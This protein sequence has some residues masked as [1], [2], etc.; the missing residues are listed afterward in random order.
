MVAMKALEEVEY[1]AV[2]W[3]DGQAWQPAV[4]LKVPLMAVF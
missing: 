1:S 4:V 3:A 2:Q